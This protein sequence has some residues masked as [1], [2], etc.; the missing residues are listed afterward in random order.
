MDGQ[1]A[2]VEY[3]VQDGTRMGETDQHR[4]VGSCP[5]SNLVSNGRVLVSPH[6]FLGDCVRDAWEVRLE[7]RSS[8]HL[9][10]LRLLLFYDLNEI[11]ES[12]EGRRDSAALSLS[13]SFLS[14]Y[15]SCGCFLVHGLVH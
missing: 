11:R 8:L 4:A 12:R 9:G 10:P 6:C 5:A 3:P 15:Q 13:V 1:R 14:L 7:P 2:A